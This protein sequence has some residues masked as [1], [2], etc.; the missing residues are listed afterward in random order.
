MIKHSLFGEREGWVRLGTQEKN[1]ADLVD[2][3]DVHAAPHVFYCWIPA[4]AGMTA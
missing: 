1:F 4:Y 3:K 2:T